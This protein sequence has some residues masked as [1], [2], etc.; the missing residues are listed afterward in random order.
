[1]PVEAPRSVDWLQ[2][3]AISHREGN[4]FRRGPLSPVRPAERGFS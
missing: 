1:M 2:I 3:R 4:R